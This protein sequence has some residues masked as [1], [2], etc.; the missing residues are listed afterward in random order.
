MTYSIFQ[1]FLLTILFALLPLI[2]FIRQQITKYALELWNT[3]AFHNF[4]PHESLV[5]TNFPKI[6]HEFTLNAP[7][8]FPS[9][10]TWVSTKILNNKPM[11]LIDEYIAPKIAMKVAPPSWLIWIC[12]DESHE[13]ILYHLRIRELVTIDYIN[14]KA[15]IFRLLKHEK[16]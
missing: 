9:C 5:R 7:K 3:L 1:L 2:C 6:W 8:T 16:L 15:P 12:L 14:A 11:L 10:I 13:I 4:W